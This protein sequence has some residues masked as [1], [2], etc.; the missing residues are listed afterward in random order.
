MGWIVAALTI[1]QLAD[2]VLTVV[3]VDRY[4]PAVEV[5]PL[6][7]GALSLGV[8]GIIAWKSALLAG[9]LISGLVGAASGVVALA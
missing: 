8:I 1:A 9:A 3:A 7:A 4:G 6:V 2:L 5:N